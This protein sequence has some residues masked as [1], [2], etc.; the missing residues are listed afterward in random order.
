[1]R[2]FPSIDALAE[3]NRPVH[4]AL[5]V[6]DGVHRGH[7]T[8]LQSARTRA[9]DQGGVAVV[10]T[11]DP[12][13]A[14]VLAADQAPKRLTHSAHQR[15]LFR[16]LGMDAAFVIPFDL[17]MAS[18]TAEGFV[19][20]LAAACQL[21]SVHVGEDWAFGNGRR[22]DLR[23]LQEL[24]QHHSFVVHGIAPV[25]DGSARISSTRIRDAVL[26]GDLPEAERLLGRP[27]SLFGPVVKGDQI[28]RR[29]GFPTA[30]V[31]F[32]A[33][34]LPPQGVYVVRLPTHGNHP[35]VAN[36]GLRPSVGGDPALKFEV[37]LLDWT[38]HLYGETLNV[39]L[40][41]ALRPE[42]HY[43][44]LTELNKQIARDLAAARRWLG[45]GSSPR[46]A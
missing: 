36:L 33:E 45:L 8:V 38:G 27:Y 46:S 11:F 30:N 10:A 40:L 25:M 24:G 19:G 20:E 2:A 9:A 26:A 6:F 14:E 43:D 28:G 17:A 15:Y 18:R 12:H 42:R 22:G 31:D 35:G 37:H 44:D 5:G 32:A 1:M 21:S 34:A 16:E 29:L 7:Q 3:L 41:H 23:L 39:T 13:P 4:L